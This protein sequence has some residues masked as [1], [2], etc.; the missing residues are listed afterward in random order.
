M[1]QT[2]FSV[3]DLKGGYR[4]ETILED[5]TFEVREGDFLGIIGP[6]GAGKTTLLR[7]MSKALFPQ[8]GKISFLGKD[9][10]NLDLK[11]FCQ[12]VAYVSQDAQLSFP[13]TVLEI[14]L[15]G[16]IPHL[17]RMQL[18]NKFDFAIAR[19]ALSM[20]D[21]LE[22]EN[23]SMDE[24]S[25][26]ERQRVIIAKALTQ[27]PILLFLDEPT[28]HLDIGHQVQVMDL[29]KRLNR[30]KK[31]TIVIVMHDLNLAGEYCNRLLLLDKGKIYKNGAPEEV[32]TYQNIEAVYKTVVVVNKSPINSRP[33]VLL[34]SG[35]K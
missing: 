10:A 33:H 19:D 29:L 1:A 7:L 32:L 28:S 9:L 31:L 24:L 6:N 21:T 30:K 15:L 27:E 14:A 17:K 4:G 26:G 8:K 35:E 18:E 11:E 12:K 13:F 16:R 5:V 22:L 2:L 23:K 3:K 20:T 34:V 25:S